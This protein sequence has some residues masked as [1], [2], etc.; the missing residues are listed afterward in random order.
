MRLGTKYGIEEMKQEALCRL[1]ACYT[2]DLARL[3]THKGDSN[4]ATECPISWKA[5]DCMGVLHLARQLDLDE[6]IPAALYRCANDVTLDQIF[7]VAANHQRLQTL[8]AQELQDCIC[9]RNDLISENIKLYDMFSELQP[10]TECSATK[11][12]LREESTCIQTMSTMVLFAHKHGYFGGS[13]ALFPMGE[14]ID[15]RTGP[16]QYCPSCGEHFKHTNAQQR[17]TA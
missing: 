8:T 3:H 14:W 12:G 16:G 5:E 7:Q 17:S 11:L 15:S 10:S 2:K 9:S 13:L 1:S 4:N 6:L